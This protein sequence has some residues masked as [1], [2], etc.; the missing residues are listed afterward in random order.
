MR[1]YSC[2]GW[3]P[4]LLLHTANRKERRDSEHLKRQQ[5]YTAA[6]DWKACSPATHSMDTAPGMRD[7]NI[8]SF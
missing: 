2:E 4:A 7:G 8:S 1:R 3:R 5:D 6:L